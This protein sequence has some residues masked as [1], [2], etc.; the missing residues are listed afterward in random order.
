M[1][2][3]KFSY[4]IYLIAALVITILIVSVYKA[5]KNHEEKLY[6]VINSKIKE[7][8]LECYLNKECSDK[9]VLE[10]LYEKG[11]LKELFDPVTKERLDNN[12]CIEYIKEE[13]KLCS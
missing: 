3:I 10:E 9:I 1:E 7:A 11:Y 6:T 5:E 8:A 13:M 2:K 12:L 4:F